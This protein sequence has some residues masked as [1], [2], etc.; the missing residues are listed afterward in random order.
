MK[1]TE[2]TKTLSMQEVLL[3]KNGDI[4]LNQ[5]IVLEEYQEFQLQQIE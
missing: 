2:F 3:L 1:L 5:I 4:S